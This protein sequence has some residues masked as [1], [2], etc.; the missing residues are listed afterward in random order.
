MYEVLV[1]MVDVGVVMLLMVYV[2]FD[3]YWIV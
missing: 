1:G 3:V 2:G